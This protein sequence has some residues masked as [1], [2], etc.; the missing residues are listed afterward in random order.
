[1]RRF[2][3]VEGGSAKFWE[4]GRDG[5]E[6]T[7]RWGR[8]GTGGQ[9]KVK[10]FD[11]PASAAAHESKLVAEKTK[12]GYAESSAGAT[13]AASPAVPPAV[14]VPT[15]VAVRDEDAFVFPPAWYR[16]RHARKGSSGTVTFTPKPD[17]RV[18]LGK[19]MTNRIDRALEAPTTDR[20]VAEQAVAW[21]EGKPDATPL[22]AAAVAAVTE[23]GN[24]RTRDQLM[25]FADAWIAERG[26]RFAAEAATELM[27]L[28][29]TDDNR[30]PQAHYLHMYEDTLGVRHLR[31]GETR[32]SYFITLAVDV[33]LRVRHALAAASDDDYADVVA[34]LGPYR[35]GHLYAR[36]ATS[37]LVPTEREWVAQDIADVVAA[38]DSYLAA[39]LTAAAGAKEELDALFPIAADWLVF[40]SLPLL[41]TMVDGVGAG[42]AAALFHWLGQ[43]VAD[44]DSRRR[45]LS[46]L[47]QL[48]GDEVMQGLIDRVDQKYVAPALLDAAERFPVR[49]MRLLAGSASKRTVADLL[50]AHVQAHPGL[51]DRVLPRLGPEAAKRVEAIVADASSLRVAPLSAVPS[52]LADP[53]WQRRG[54][55][56]KPVVLG[57]LECR[58]PAA[59]Q[60][61]D[62]ERDAWAAVHF[63]RYDQGFGAQPWEM[64]SRRVRSG[65]AGWLEGASFFV[66]AP[67]AVARPVLAHWNPTDT[68]MAGDWMRVIVARF[69]LDSLPLALVVARRSPAEAGKVLAPF[70]SVEVAVLMAE[71][72]GR[73]KSVR[74]V[75]LAWLLRHSAGAARALVPAALG[76]AGV[77]RRQAENALLALHH[78]GQGDT[79]RAAAR[80]YGAEAAAAVDALLESDPLAVLPARMPALPS[81]ATPGLLPP[82]KLRD[83]SGVLPVE[84]VT[85]VITVLAISRLDTPYAGVDVLKGACDPVSLAEFGWSLF[86]RWQLSGS[87]SKENWVLDTLGLIGDDETVRLLSPLVLAWPGE[88]GHTKAVTGLAVLAAIGTDVALMHL[89]GIAQRAKFKGLKAAAQQ[90]MDEVAAGLGLSAEQ[91]ADRLVPDLGL[92]DDGSMRL[93][94]GPRQFTV[95]F[96]EQLRPFVADAA[97][98]RLKALPKPGV[99]DDDE[100]APAAYRT[101]SGLKKDVR[102]IAAD[103]IRRLERAMVTGRRWTGAEFRR[104]FVSHPLLWHIVRRLV[105]GRYDESGALI[106]ALRVAEDRSLATV[107]DDETTIADDAI[108]GVAHPLQ[109]GDTLPD[110]VEMFADYEILQPFPQLSRPTFTLTEQEAASSRLSR[111]EG[112]TVPTGRVIGLERRGWRRETP[113]DAGIQGCIELAVDGKREVVIDLDPGVAVGAMDIFPEQKLERIYLWSGD[114][115]RW[116]NRTEGAQ[117]LGELDAITVSEVIRDLTEI[118]A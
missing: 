67:E 100:L 112:V 22:G 90:K 50:R 83:G 57:G 107:D 33:A 5:S 3:F 59:I 53:P 84:A 108:V 52:M 98:K 40:R 46:V 103:Q 99:R 94:Y 10:A 73:L 56:A 113:Q 54:K 101:F 37:V 26:L 87:P 62:G 25:Y 79:V 36:A 77:P 16:H 75:A 17:A 18:V 23:L 38:D 78:H 51:V 95:G 47:E 29:V 105:W 117:A 7:V 92:D 81:W 43:D 12:K 8:V 118:T 68:W 60:W 72:F 6:V 91:L 13:A 109:L 71:W 28:K 34:A 70:F 48:P 114:G 69:G 116:G 9:T 55:A 65:D 32:D 4:I 88:G 96:D 30:P 110:W 89:H 42:A 104:L 61:A 14:A 102:T 39:F 35:A 21:R 31:A 66:D 11:D 111:F 76:K 64:R 1:M 49:A 15:P 74:A 20:A 86:Q 63:Y 2:E 27:S 82:I 41:V 97:G 45:L 58:E 106:G 85:H 80:E 19:E 93:D 115:S 24:W 44:A